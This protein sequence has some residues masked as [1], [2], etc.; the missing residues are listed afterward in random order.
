MYP[1]NRPH[2][3][4]R[5]AIGAGLLVTHPHGPLSL[6]LGRAG[7][8]ARTD[9]APAPPHPA[10][11]PAERCRCPKQ[12]ARQRPA[13]RT[14]PPGRLRADVRQRRSEPAGGRDPDSGAGR[15]GRDERPAS[16]GRPEYPA[17]VLP[18]EDARRIYEEIVRSR[19]D[20]ALIEI[21][22]HGLIRLSAFPIPPGGSRQVSFRYSQSITPR[23]GRL[24]LLFPIA[25]LAG[26]DRVGPLD[27]S[28]TIDGRESLAQVYS[29]SHDIVIER[30]GPRTA[31]LR[32]EE[33]YPDPHETLEVIAV[34][35]ESPMGVDLRTARGHREDDYFLLAV[36][37]GWNLLNERKQAPKTVIFV[38]DRSG[39]MQGSKFEQARRALLQMIE[40]TAPDDRFNLISF[41]GEVRS[42]F[43]DGPR[44]AT[45]EARRRAG[46]WIRGL[47][48]T[49]GTAIADAIEE[50][51]RQIDRAGLVL[52]LTDGLPT[53]GEQDHDAI[54]RRAR[55]RGSSI[56]F[57]AFGVGYDVDATLLDDLARQGGGSVSYVRPDESVEEA[58]ASLR[59][60]VEYPC[61]RNVRLQIDGARV[62]EVYPRGAARS[63]RRR[64]AALRRTGRSGS[65]TCHGPAHRRRARRTG[66]SATPGPSTSTMRRRAAPPCRSC[67]RPGRRPT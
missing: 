65:R 43:P 44:R 54:V 25:V 33:Q 63:L 50:A 2:R 48:A 1:I 59:Q 20:P 47:S 3:G 62:H 13:R 42:L 61:A 46:E 64:A 56:R 55:A 8:D 53:V 67:G 39:S 32:F 41:S 58:I 35:D 57:Y 6:P 22:G 38:L 60:R 30:E 66:R 26:L 29:P 37:P 51:Y 36:S 9:H 10:H 24:R 14:D 45:A 16:R 18:A 4:P 49:G 34:R 52:F 5:P 40:Q 21:A 7:P 31:S 23:E 28:L 11:C 19:R 27:L 12:H 15:C 17:E